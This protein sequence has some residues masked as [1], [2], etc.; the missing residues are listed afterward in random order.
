MNNE[1]LPTHFYSKASQKEALD[2]VTRQYEIL[3]GQAHKFILNDESHKL[4]SGD[5][6]DQ[7]TEIIGDYLTTHIR[8]VKNIMLGLRYVASM[9]I[10]SGDWLQQEI[11]SN[12]CLSLKNQ[13]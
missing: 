1:T 2:A 10:R 7:L 8:F 6:Y 5:R 12:P 3:R 13:R 11:T 9:L 4:R